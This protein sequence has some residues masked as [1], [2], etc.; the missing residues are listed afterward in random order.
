MS[1]N[2][3]RGFGLSLAV[4]LSG[5]SL[6]SLARGQVIATPPPA[7]GTA[8]HAGHKDGAELESLRQAHRLLVEADHDYDG[9]RARAAEEVHKAIKELEGKHHAKKAQAGVAPVV[10]SKPAAPKEPAVHEAQANSDA[11]LRQAQTI[12]QG[13]HGSLISRHHKAAPNVATA[14]AEINTALKIK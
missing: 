10:A 14:I 3:V 2:L 11:Q 6:A 8:K 12:L 1:G 7:G 13:V 4:F 5:L 9:H